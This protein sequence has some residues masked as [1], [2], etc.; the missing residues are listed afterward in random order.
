MCCQV[1]VGY[2]MADQAA[3][4]VLYA[5][6]NLVYQDYDL[7]YISHDGPQKFGTI[8]YYIYRCYPKHRVELRNIVRT[9]HNITE[10]FFY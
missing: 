3:D 6:K 1:K 7:L 8:I 4:M 10:T 5:E 2:N 9:V